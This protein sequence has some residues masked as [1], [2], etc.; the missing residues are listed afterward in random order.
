MKRKARAIGI[1]FDILPD[2]TEA[3]SE[4]ECGSRGGLFP[5]Y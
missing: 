3:P 4:P 2:P 1:K 5:E